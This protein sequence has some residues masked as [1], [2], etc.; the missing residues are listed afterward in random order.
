MP[1]IEPNALWLVQLVFPIFP[2]QQT[3]YL[4][5]NTEI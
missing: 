3:N 2:F 4:K 5:K 1:L